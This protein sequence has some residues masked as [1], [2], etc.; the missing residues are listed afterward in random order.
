MK[1]ATLTGVVTA[2]TVGV[3]LA[4]PIDRPTIQATSSKPS[5]AALGV[6]PIAKVGERLPGR[7]MPPRPPPG[8]PGKTAYIRLG[9]VLGREI[10]RWP[11]AS[12]AAV[13][14]THLKYGPP[15]EHT[16]SRVT[17]RDVGP[18]KRVVVHREPV[19]HAFPYPHE[20]VLEQVIGFDVPVHRLDDV[21]AIHGSLTARR[22]RGELASECDLEA[23]NFLSL[24]LAY[25]V[26][27][28]QQSAAAARDLLA[29]TAFAYR[30]G[31]RTPLTEGLTFDRLPTV[32][33]PDVATVK[34]TRR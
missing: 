33:D 16:A 15:A 14:N 6:D 25:Q 7:P 20:D 30:R 9:A 34:L 26:I 24:N 21:A 22:T 18:W 28:D 3:A 2:L 27:T 13:T 32:G 29:K 12:R 31:V 10:R 11:A 5:A 4:Q 8:E 1:T 17:W 23:M 19:A